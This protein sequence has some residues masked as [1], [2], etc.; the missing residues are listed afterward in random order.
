MNIPAKLLQYTNGFG[1]WF[2]TL[3]NARLSARDEKKNND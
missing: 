2:I 1:Y 3:K